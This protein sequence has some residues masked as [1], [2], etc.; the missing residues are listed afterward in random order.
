LTKKRKREKRDRR[1]QR[2]ER[3]RGREREQ[4]RRRGN[5]KRKNRPS[6]SITQRDK[7]KEK[8]D[9]GRPFVVVDGRIAASLS[10]SPPTLRPRGASHDS[11]SSSSLSISRA[12]SSEKR[13]H[14]V[15]VLRESRKKKRR[16]FDGVESSTLPLPFP[17]LAASPYLRASV[18]LFSS[19][20][21]G[22]TGSKGPYQV[23]PWLTGKRERVFPRP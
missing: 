13:E 12:E 4:E 9:V 5:E 2:G 16:I 20:T 10:F 7:K 3:E 23:P 18:L 8:K 6:F 17:P 11:H 14:G 15:C 22:A 21:R 19:P 1:E